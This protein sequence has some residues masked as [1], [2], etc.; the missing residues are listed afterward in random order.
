[1][2]AGVQQRGLI[3]KFHSF[4]QHAIVVAASVFLAACGGGATTNPNQGGELR[5]S[6]TEGTFF[7]GV[8][9]TITI[10]GGR[11]PYSITSSAPQILP[12]PSV[13]NANSFQVVPNNPAVL[14]SSTGAL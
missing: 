7:A 2:T 14:T 5:V 3:V 11:I 4:I 12:V 8:P 13:V 6:P 1:M 10:S 9:S